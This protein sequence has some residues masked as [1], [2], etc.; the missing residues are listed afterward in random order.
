[1]KHRFGIVLWTALAAAAF[2]AFIG[3]SAASAG[4]WSPIEEVSQFGNAYPERLYQ[5]EAADGTKTVY[6]ILD[7]G[8]ATETLQAVRLLGDGTPGPAIDIADL[9]ADEAQGLEAVVDSSGKITFAW[10]ASS[11]GSFPPNQVKS[12]QLDADGSVGAVTVIAEPAAP[13]DT[14]TQLSIAVTPDRTVAYAWRR[15]E[16]PT[17]S[18]SWME[19][20][21]VPDGGAAGELRIYSEAPISIT[22]PNVVALPTNQFKLAWVA[23]DTD[24]GFGNI[25]TLDIQ[26][27]GTP[28]GSVFYIFPRTEP[29][30]GIVNDVCQ[31]LRDPETNQPL[32]KPSGATGDP[33]DLEVGSNAAGA[34]NLAWRRLVV[35]GQRDCD[36]N[37]PVIESEQL[38]V[39]TVRIDEFGG[40]FPTAQASPPGVDVLR[41]DINAPLIG[42]STLAWFAED[43]G[44]FSTQIFR[45]SDAGIWTISN[46]D[47]F[48]APTMIA[49]SDLSVGIGWTQGGGVP[50]QGTARAA[51]VTRNGL[52]VQADIPGLDSLAASSRT[53]AD[54]GSDGERRVTFFGR[55][56]SAEGGLWQS[57][58]SDPRLKISP[59]TVTFP[60]TL[61]NTASPVSTAFIQNTGTTP[62]DVLAVQITGTDSSQFELVDA[63]SCDIT[64]GP[65]DFCGVKVRFRP[66]S[67]GQ[68]EASLD[69][70]GEGSVVWTDLRGQAEAKTRLRV[71]ARPANRT[72]RP[73]GRVVYRVVVSNR[74]GLDAS[75]TRVCL[76]GPSAA[77]EPGKRCVRV[78]SLATGNS[79]TVRIAV[80]ARNSALP[81]TST[82][83]FIASA[84]NARA[85][86]TSTTL[87]IRR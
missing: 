39:E 3:P 48:V 41:I 37:I 70:T 78:G 83:I 76:R 36:G 71:Q 55:N 27:D 60:G 30:T 29:L 34:I 20:R 18:Q 50:S 45:F 81:R 66:D 24:S 59:P 40:I 86:R 58:F 25:A 15:N 5:L 84:N 22:D 35:T 9:S 6:W 2:A 10:L 85:T 64:L 53:L 33:R 11:T 68:K 26:A 57:G 23:N 65:G 28:I 46:D 75:G 12:V 62:A 56:L 13:D 61:V 31:Q 72:L 8:A 7:D 77:V 16:A 38:A 44:S 80:R 32:T 19:G 87:R 17:F 69:V 74:G 14:I 4:T 82:L 47:N 21:T 51:F 63:A 79:R 67:G 43:D 1:L 54:P 52:L 73:G 42:R 49:G